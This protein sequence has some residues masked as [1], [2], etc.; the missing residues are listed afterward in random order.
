[1]GRNHPPAAWLALYGLAVRVCERRQPDE[2]ALPNAP[3]YL[4]LGG[5]TGFAFMALSLLLLWV[6]GLNDVARGH[7]QYGFHYLVFNAY[8]SGVVE[9]LGFRAILLRIF[10]RMF[11]PVPGLVISSFLFAL[12]HASHVPP[13]ALAL[14]VINGG[15]LLGV[16]YIV[17]GSLW[18]PIGVHIA[19]DFTEWSLFGVGDKDGYLVVTPSAGHAA[20][21]TGGTTGPDGSVLSALISIAL[22]AA[23]LFMARPRPGKNALQQVPAQAREA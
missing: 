19:Y 17:S 9:E 1:M 13:V 20:W 10:A 15:L 2:I 5:A 23:V 7:W 16:L 8:I 14:L 3:S 21:L 22:I 18:L 6:F 4:L 11:G 12:A